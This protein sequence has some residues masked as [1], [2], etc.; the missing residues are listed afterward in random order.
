M[1]LCVKQI[2]HCLISFRITSMFCVY[3]TFVM[4]ILNEYKVYAYESVA[5]W[6]EVDFW[7]FKFWDVYQVIWHFPPLF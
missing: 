1:S 4:W 2:V 5:W 3:S 6:L 7:V